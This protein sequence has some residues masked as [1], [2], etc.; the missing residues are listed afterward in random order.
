MQILTLWYSG[1]QCREPQ[2]PIGTYFSGCLAYLM[3]V[4]LFV[5]FDAILFIEVIMY[6]Q[7]VGEL[8]I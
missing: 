5:S 1:F 4:R 3:F 8:K 2:G 6:A 7:N